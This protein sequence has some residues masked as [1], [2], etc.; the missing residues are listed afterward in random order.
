MR[1]GIDE[2]GKKTHLENVSVAIARTI[3]EMPNELAI[4]E[5]EQL[6]V[7]LIARADRYIYA[8]SQYFASRRIA[9]A[10]AKRVAE[11]NGPE[12]VIVNPLSAD[13][14]LETVAMDSA[15]AR[16]FQAI[17]RQ[18]KRD[19]LRI[20]HPVTDS[21]EP[22]YV[23]SK[24]M[25]VDDWALRVG[26]SNMNNRSMRL[27]SECDVTIDNMSKPCKKTAEGISAVMFDLIGE[28][29]DIAADDIAAEF[30]LSHSIT[31]S[32][33]KLRGEGHSLR[34][35]TVP[36]LTDTEKYLADHEVLDPEGPE[37]MFEAMST[38]S[39][40]RGRLGRFNAKLR[41]KKKEIAHDRL[42]R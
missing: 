6:Y 15:R 34:H 7:D 25:I 26:S 41:R 32:I 42:R 5:I 16:L 37:E 19:R 18:D 28:H 33:E 13:G 21:G 36:E 2:K 12:I 11:E 30:A 9:Q 38:R 35:Y 24:V 23:H 20:Y 17:K 8:G 40:F 31:S 27:D 10:I 39:I 14:W 1:D 4:L 22:I 3:G 29:L